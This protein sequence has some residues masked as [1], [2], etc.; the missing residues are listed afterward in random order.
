MFHTTYLVF[1]DA[2]CSGVF[3]YNHRLNVY[4]TVHQTSTT[5][6]YQTCGRM[7]DC[8]NVYI[9]AQFLYFGSKQM[10]MESMLVYC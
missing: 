6:N 5:V 9:I 8:R 10:P 4:Y 2:F 1:I 7:I 3:V